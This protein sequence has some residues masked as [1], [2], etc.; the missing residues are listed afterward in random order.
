MANLRL[1]F[2]ENESRKI[3]RIAMENFLF[4]ALETLKLSKASRE[5]ILERV[6]LKGKE[7]LE[8]I[9]EGGILVSCHLGNFPLIC[10]RLSLE[11][12]RIGVVIKL[13]R[14]PFLAKM[15]KQRGEKWGLIFIEIDDRYETVLR[16]QKFLKEGGVLLLMLDQNPRSKGVIVPFWGLPTPTYRTPLLLAQKTRLP[17]LPV[18]IY[19]KEGKHYLEV[20]EPF[21]LSKDPFKDLEALNAIIQRYVSSFPEQWWWWHRRWRNILSYR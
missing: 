4:F 1:I 11:G 9:K 5:E 7:N 19:Q 15:V 13:P 8:R 3:L 21:N 20:L 12:F 10:F 2:S 16:V 18:F 17:L 6:F 14:D